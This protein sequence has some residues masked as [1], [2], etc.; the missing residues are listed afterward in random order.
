MV[1]LWR[2]GA[3]KVWKGS[4]FLLTGTLTKVRE[5]RGRS[6]TLH[7]LTIP[8]IVL[9]HGWPSCGFPT[10][11]SEPTEITSNS[12]HVCSTLASVSANI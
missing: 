6:V 11:R 10:R 5:Y 7:S 3:V 2:K 8:N 4:T 9:F 1:F 12:R